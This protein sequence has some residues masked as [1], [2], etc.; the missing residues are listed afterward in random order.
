MATKSEFARIA[1]VS[2]GRVSQWITEGKIGP[3]ALIGE[4]RFAKVKIELALRQVRDRR[5]A[6]QSLGNGLGTKL[7]GT[8]L[9]AGSSADDDLRSARLEGLK[10]QNRRLEEE[11]LRR[12]G[13]YVRANDAAAATVKMVDQMMATFESAIGELGAKLKESLGSEAAPFLDEVWR[14]K[15]RPRVEATGRRER[16]AVG[17]Q[18]DGRR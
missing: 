3:D 10:L 9:S 16:A 13:R 5:D 15:V 18:A 6:G 2:R 11:A 1:G 14:E 8:D 7:G 17:V 4:G 12:R